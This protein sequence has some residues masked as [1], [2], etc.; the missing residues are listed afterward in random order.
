[1]PFSNQS[2]AVVERNLREYVNEYLPQAARKQPATPIDRS[3]RGWL[4]RVVLPRLLTFL[5]VLAILWGLFQVFQHFF[6][7]RPVTCPEKT[8]YGVAKVLCGIDVWP[9]GDTDIP[10]GRAY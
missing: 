10:F 7:P 8:Q 1:M 6:A 4:R 9:Y 3:F 5:I 2:R